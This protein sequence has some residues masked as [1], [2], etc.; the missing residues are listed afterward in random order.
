M[1]AH[2]ALAALGLLGLPLLYSASD[3]LT[4]VMQTEVVLPAP[5]D[6]KLPS[7]DSGQERPPMDAIDL[8]GLDTA[9]PDR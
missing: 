1:R 5:P 3:A 7:L 4:A 2:R 9:T 8:E 6:L